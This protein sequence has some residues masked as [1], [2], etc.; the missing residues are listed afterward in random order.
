MKLYFYTGFYLQTSAWFDLHMCLIHAL[1]FEVI[2]LSS[3]VGGIRN[4]IIVQESSL[5]S[6][7]KLQSLLI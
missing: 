7:L 2:F 6:P 5:F 1:F 3:A 4:R